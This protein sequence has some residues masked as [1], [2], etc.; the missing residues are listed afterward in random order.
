M[1]P[2]NEIRLF[3]SVLSPSQLTALKKELLFSNHLPTLTK[4]AKK[5][6][7]EWLFKTFQADQKELLPIEYLP[8]HALNMLTLLNSEE[9]NHLIDLL[10]MRDL[11]HEIKQIIDTAQLKK[12]HHALSKEELS[13][14]KT[15]MHHKEPITFKRITLE[16][17]DGQTETLRALLRQ[18]GVNRL[19]KALFG[20]SSSLLW[21]VSH[22]M[23]MTTATTLM[24]LCTPLDHPRAHAILSSQVIEA[25]ETIEPQHLAQK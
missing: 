22:H 25:L 11:A 16:H 12:I 8:E 10:S 24:Q 17:W 23:E 1:L 20:Q 13:T 18:R 6:L 14:L 15:L 5:F 2:E 4:P 3:L 21:H 9:L 19:A 7:Q